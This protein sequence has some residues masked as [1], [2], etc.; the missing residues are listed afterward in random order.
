MLLAGNL[1]WV[2]AGLTLIGVGTFFAQAAAT[3]FVG[4]AAI[5]D[6]TA[7]SGLYL[8]SYYLGGLAGAALLGQIYDLFGWSATV[9]GIGIAMAAAMVLAARLVSAEAQP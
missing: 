7:A 9:F 4:Q 8:A 3:G 1:P 6:R 2:L 5:S